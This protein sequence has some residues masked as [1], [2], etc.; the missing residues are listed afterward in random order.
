MD[1]SI[2]RETADHVLAHAGLNYGLPPAV[3]SHQGVQSAEARELMRLPLKELRRQQQVPLRRFERQL[4]LVMARVLS[5]DLPAMAFDPSSWRIEFSESETPLDPKAEHELF[6]S[7]RAAGL[8]NTLSHMQ[9]LRPGISEDQALAALE[10]NILVELER[11]RLMRPLQAISGSLGA[12][13]PEAPTDSTE[14]N[15]EAE[16]ENASDSVQ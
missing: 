5:V 6:L 16:S 9:R 8:D 14:D 4:A 15:A 7:R 2:F 10:T 3:L 12:D 11:N 13:T 1:L